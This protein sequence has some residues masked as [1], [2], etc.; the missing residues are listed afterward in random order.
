MLENVLNENGAK[1]DKEFIH[2]EDDGVI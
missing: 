1:G 2:D